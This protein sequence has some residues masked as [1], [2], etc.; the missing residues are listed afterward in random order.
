MVAKASSRLEVQIDAPSAL[1]DSR[2]RSDA[3]ATGLRRPGVSRVFRRALNSELH[4]RI[5]KADL[6]TRKRI[7]DPDLYAL[8]LTEHEI[9]ATS[10]ASIASHFG[11]HLSLSC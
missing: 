10:A 4:A 9:D 2:G 3:Q 7:L 1:L 5:T 11:D 8:A 6:N